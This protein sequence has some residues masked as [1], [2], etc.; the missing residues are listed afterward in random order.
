MQ[1]SVSERVNKANEEE[2]IASAKSGDEYAFELLA[3]SYKRV[4]QYHI[5]RIDANPSNYDDLFQE[6]LIGL[7]KAVRSYDGTSSSFATYASLCVRN[8]IISGVRK[9]AT[10]TSNTI[11]V[12]ECLEEETSPSAE[13][14]LLD[15]VRAGQLYDKV[16]LSLSP[17]EKTVFDMYL[18]DI[19]YESIA[20]V[21]GK[22]VK[23]ISNAVF[24]IR[25]KLRQ[26]VGDARDIAEEPK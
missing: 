5:K 15:R 25:S 24:R 20:F 3:E 22:S 6:G 26:I 4:L 8:S 14:V 19:P 12:S 17:Y 2:L 23:S 9:Y 21:T 7:L 18:S 10:Q 16:Y 13:E 1:K 11:S